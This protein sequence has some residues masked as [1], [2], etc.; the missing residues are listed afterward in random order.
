MAVT[1]SG[2]RVS[3]SSA[4]THTRALPL[5]LAAVSSLRL[6][7]GKWQGAVALPGD[8]GGVMMGASGQGPQEGCLLV[9]I[10]RY[11]YSCSSLDS[12][13]A[14]GRKMGKRE[15]N[16]GECLPRRTPHP[17]HLR[18]PSPSIHTLRGETILSPSPSLSFSFPLLP[19]PPVLPSI[20]SGWALLGSHLPEQ[21]K[22]NASGQSGIWPRINIKQADSHLLHAEGV[23][24]PNPKDISHLNMDLCKPRKWKS[25]D[26]TGRFR[27]H[28]KFVAVYTW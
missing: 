9:V 20:P 23:K 15:A 28:V 26:S 10:P 5:L 11:L 6:I 18:A 12:L 17:I 21:V 8:L 3:P 7:R 25:G 1:L 22:I 4:V 19:S 24:V 14:L 2:E 27:L 16:S 13:F